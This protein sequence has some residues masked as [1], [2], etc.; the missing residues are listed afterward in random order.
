M[1]NLIDGMNIEKISLL[2]YHEIGQY[3]YNKLKLKYKENLMKTPSNEKI[4]EIKKLFEKKY[5]VEIGG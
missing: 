3:K 4:E 2:P 1:I 5:F